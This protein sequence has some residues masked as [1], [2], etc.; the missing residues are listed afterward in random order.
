VSALGDYDYTWFDFQPDGAL[1]P[2]EPRDE[3]P[4]VRNYLAAP[5]EKLQ[6]IA[7]W[8]QK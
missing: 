4:E 1:V 3:Y 7:A 2:H 6:E 8:I 5:R